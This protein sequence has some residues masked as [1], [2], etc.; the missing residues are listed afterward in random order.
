MMK[1][2]WILMVLLIGLNAFAEDIE[3]P[4]EELARE[5]TLPV[6]SKR[7][8]VLNRNVVTTEKFEFGAGAGWQ[9]NEPYYNN[10]MFGVQGTYNFTDVSAVNVQGLFWNKGLSS[11][12]EQLKQAPPASK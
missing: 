12:G 10:L 3:V 2:I 6:F 4:E 8:I 9:L 5:T 7:R 1:S 11:Y